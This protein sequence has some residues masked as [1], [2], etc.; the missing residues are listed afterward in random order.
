MMQEV[1]EAEK[2]C[3]S[4]EDETR[5]IQLAAAE[6]LRACHD[7]KACRTQHYLF[8]RRGTNNFVRLLFPTNLGALS[9]PF[10][11]MLITSLAHSQRNKQLQ[12]IS[13]RNLWQCMPMNTSPTI[14]IYTSMKI[15]RE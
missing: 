12:I 7:E 5:R 6:L 4:I 15:L 8:F 1:F 14:K 3:N 10:Q 13:R 11:S 2:R 9:K